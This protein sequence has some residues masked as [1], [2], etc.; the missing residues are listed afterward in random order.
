MKDLFEMFN[1]VHSASW[2]CTE[3]I[4]ERKK[5]RTC[6][7]EA[8]RKENEKEKARNICILNVGISKRVN[9][10]SRSDILTHVL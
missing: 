10:E 4:I 5:K 9:P 8:E 1:N 3:M 7:R 2:Y 6:M